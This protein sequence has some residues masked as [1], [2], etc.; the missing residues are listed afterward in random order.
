MAEPVVGVSLC[1]RY[2]VIERL[3]DGERS[4]VPAKFSMEQVVELL[5][6]SLLRTSYIMDDL[7]VIGRQ[8]N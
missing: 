7:L 3:Q 5:A 6:K 8:E 2:C 1:D 4:G